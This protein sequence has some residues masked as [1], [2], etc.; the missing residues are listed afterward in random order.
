M[1]GDQIKVIE[2]LRKAEI[3]QSDRWINYWHDYSNIHTW[4]FWVVL[5][6]FVL[7]LVILI[8]FIDRRK[9]FQLGF[10]G[11]SVH[12]F[13][14]IIDSY[15]VLRGLWTYPYKMLPSLPASV[16]LDS[17]FVPVAYILLYQ[18]TINKEK[19][20]YIWM[21]LLCLAFAFFVKPLMVGFGLFRFGGNENF[22]MLFWGY[23]AVGLIAK[24]ISDVFGVLLK[25]KK[26]SFYHKYS[27]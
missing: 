5:A 9:I 13:F 27:K 14:A 24:W 25:T 20:Y 15:G 19:N 26:W 12:V 3:E 2:Q 23:V 21:L 10:Y 16:A 11:Y 17:S 22:L 6:M 1:D 4:G 7:P 18:Y 8:L